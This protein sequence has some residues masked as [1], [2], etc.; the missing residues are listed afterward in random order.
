MK[1][2]TKQRGLT[3]IEILISMTLGLII[4][5]AI[6]QVFVSGYRMNQR[7]QLQSNIDYLATV[8]NDRFQREFT[9]AGYVD[10]F[11][12]EHATTLSQSLKILKRSSQQNGI[13]FLQ[14]SSGGL[15]P[16]FGCDGAFGEGS[17][18]IPNTTNALYG[19]TQIEVARANLANKKSEQ[20]VYPA[21]DNSAPTANSFQVAYQALAYSTN[22]DARY[23][24]SLSTEKHAETGR[25]FDCL[26]QPPR[27]GDHFIVNQYFLEDVDINGRPVKS[28]FCRGSGADDAQ[29]LV[30][31]VEELVVNYLITAND[32][33]KTAAG[34]SGQA[35]WFY[36]SGDRARAYVNATEMEHMRTQPPAQSQKYRWS[37]ITAVEVCF[38]LAG[39]ARHGESRSGESWQDV[40][41]NIPT[42][43]RD[44]SGAFMPS[45]A[46]PDG[47]GRYYE[48]YVNT[49][50]VSNLIYTS[51]AM[52]SEA[53][54]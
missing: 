49:F 47:D 32:D 16:V 37:D 21:C 53:T 35:G 1:K 4:L 48:R 24:P 26:G 52:P 5:L 54:P 42:C 12:G 34:Q 29:V 25:G 3:L 19:S 38:V 8:I 33:E 10:F 9:N 50:G 31:G 18:S 46:R 36:S 30:N 39:T 20:F 41:P 28:L 23:A 44:S 43:A 51:S 40:Q 7:T 11:A 15:M 13:T 6:A 22:G 17:S 2:R 14:N 45:K 27:A